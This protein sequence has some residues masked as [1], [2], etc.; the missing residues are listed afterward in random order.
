MHSELDDLLEELN[1]RTP[2]NEDPNTVLVVPP[3]AVVSDLD[4]M[5]ADVH[6]IAIA[7]I[8]KPAPERIAEPSRSAV[9]SHATMI[10]S[11]LVPELAAEITS[12]PT[13]GAE[14]APDQVQ[15][16]PAHTERAPVKHALVKA[17]P[18]PKPVPIKVSI[19]KVT[20]PKVTIPKVSIPKINV[21][22]IPRKAVLIGASV[23]VILAVA[24]GVIRWA[25]NCP[26]ATK[27]VA[28]AKPAP[29]ATVI[30]A[31]SATPLVATAPAVAPTP[32]ITSP[33]APAD[34]TSPTSAPTAAV[35]AAAPTR[36]TAPV[37]AKPEPSEKTVVKAEPA[38]APIVQP[39]PE[40][41]PVA[42]SAPVK[43]EPIVK[44]ETHAIAK[45]DWQDKADSAM[46]AYLNKH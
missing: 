26:A 4:E 18:A 46:D 38:T 5:Q 28:V 35:T 41:K 45:K 27:T 40:S 13:G 12:E 42:K 31:K 29:A 10:A 16:S 30:S 39:K 33:P 21:P 15:P 2:T 20:L 14:S 24:G 36:I 43:A 17:E 22:K 32:A 3:H 6:A 23:V 1:N 37:K 9:V 7:P 8:K 34:T 11:V 25:I 44:K 19:P